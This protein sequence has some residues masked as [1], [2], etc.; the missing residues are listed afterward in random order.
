MLLACSADL[1]AATL[2]RLRMFVLRARC[3]LSDAS[4]ELPLYGLVGRA[5]HAP[6]WRMP[7]RPRCGTS[8]SAMDSPRSACP[9]RPVCARY[10]CAGGAAPPLQPLSLEAW[11]WLEVRSGVARIE[12]ATVEQ[13][14]PQMLN[15]ELLGGVDFQ[16][17]CYP[18]QEVVARSQYRGSV[19]RRSFL[20]ETDAAALGRRG[21]VP[22]GRSGAAGRQGRQRRG[23]ARRPRASGSLALVELKLA[24]LGGGSLHLGA[25]RRPALRRVEL[26]YAL[27]LESH[28]RMKSRA[29][30]VC[31][32]RPGIASG[33]AR[34]SSVRAPRRG[35]EG[36]VTCGTQR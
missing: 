31:D 2:K 14:V 12:Q 9:T 32:R 4:A 28:L 11:R 29:G 1:L 24:A 8:A 10:L 33:S 36:D 26:P 20:F 6:G 19:K 25:A 22:C 23:A 5:G 7:R 35:S 27:P 3:V 17:G 30:C 13:F 34:G 18:G 16:K 15:Y 21:G